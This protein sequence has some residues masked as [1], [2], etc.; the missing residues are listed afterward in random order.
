[1]ESSIDVH[2]DPTWVSDDR[3]DLSPILLLHGGSVSSACS[4]SDVP[5][6]LRRNHRVVMSDRRG[7][8]HTGDTPEPFHY[9]SM[10]QEAAAVIKD[11]TSDRERGL[12]TAQR[13]NV[14]IHGLLERPELSRAMAST[15]GSST[16]A[17]RI[18][19]GAGLDDREGLLTSTRYIHPMEWNTGL[20][21][22]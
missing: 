19:S 15:S 6:R 1:M 12:A 18:P 17:R 4:W 2:G 5:D 7:H 22:P 11:S 21:S 13:K 14:L 20:S 8:G 9:R 16:T 3:S 10:V